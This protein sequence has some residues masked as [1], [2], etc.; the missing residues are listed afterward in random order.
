MINAF[1][2]CDLLENFRKILQQTEK[3]ALT[4]N[5]QPE[6]SLGIIVNEMRT[7]FVG[8]KISIIRHDPIKVSGVKVSRLGH[9]GLLCLIHV[10]AYQAHLP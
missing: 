4:V 9:L 1:I 2:L 7:M 10:A 3:E 8:R 6:W 5:A